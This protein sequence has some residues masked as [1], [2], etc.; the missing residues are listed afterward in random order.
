MNKREKNIKFS[1]KTEKDNSFSFLD[2]KI[3]REK[4][5]FTTSVF[6]KNTFSGVYT[7]YSSSVALEHKFGLVHT[8]LHRSFT[9]VPGF[10]KFQFQVETLKKTPHKIPHKMLIP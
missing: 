5:K 1:F 3:C 8:F 4:N 6:R 2:V 10:S 9:I 7:K